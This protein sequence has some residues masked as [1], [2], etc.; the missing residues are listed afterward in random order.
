LN[1]IR[2]RRGEIL[3]VARKHSARDVR[4]FGSVVRGDNNQ[5]SDIDFL[6]RMEPDR[7]LLD[8]IEFMQELE[9]M[10]Q[11]KVDVVNEKALHPLIREQVLKEGKP[12]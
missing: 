9:D 4:V 7:S 2:A 3:E 12:L 1:D 8:R 5:A 10:L 6:I 11:V